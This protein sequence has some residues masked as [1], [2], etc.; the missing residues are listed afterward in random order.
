[1]VDKDDI[2]H[3]EIKNKVEMEG[4]KYVFTEKSKECN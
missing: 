3:I 4:E 1:M 2:N